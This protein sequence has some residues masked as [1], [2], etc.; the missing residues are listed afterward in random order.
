[1]AIFILWIA[2][3][4]VAA[5]IAQNKGRSVG[6]FFLL[7]LLL[8]PVIGILAAL[9]ATTNT[10][11]VERQQIQSGRS[12]KCP[13]CAEII[14]S[15]ASVCRFCGKD[16]PIE[17][18]VPIEQLVPIVQI[19]PPDAALEARFEA[20]LKPQLTPIAPLTPAMRAEYRK[21][22]NSKVSKG[23]L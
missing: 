1:M 23:E 2:L 10:S 15:E 16:Q 22:F 14:K 17:Q 7:S 6:G 12:K 19:A 9:V 11:V 20:W 3:S 13:Y 21:A 8:S 4:F 18:S 5:A